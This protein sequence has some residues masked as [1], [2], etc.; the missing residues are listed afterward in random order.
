M[1][2]VE[3]PPIS[4][5]NVEVTDANDD[6]DVEFGDWNG[7]LATKRESKMLVGSSLQG[8][9]SIVLAFA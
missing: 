2:D 1:G 6:A 7:R 9:I 8:F 5:A 4:H 3:Q